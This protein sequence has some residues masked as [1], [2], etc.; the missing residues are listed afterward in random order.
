MLLA[1]NFLTTSF[2]QKKS[3]IKSEKYKVKTPLML[4]IIFF[5]YFKAVIFFKEI[6]VEYHRGRCLMSFIL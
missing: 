5:I 3:E 1:I 6:T 2:C 4:E